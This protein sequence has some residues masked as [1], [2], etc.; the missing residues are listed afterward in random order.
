MA[1]SH[2]SASG[3]RRME[4]SRSIVVL[5]AGAVG[6]YLGGKLADA[7]KHTIT[8][9]GRAGLVDTVSAR[10]LIM[11]E[12]GKKIVTH[13]KATTSAA[14]LPPCDL[15][16]LAVRTYD[17]RDAIKDVRLLDLNRPGVQENGLVL[18]VQNGAGSDDLLP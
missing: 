1:R 4:R 18:G 3:A 2:L 16:I 17:V 13:P 15:V 12:E 10:G 5:G 9:V 8:L 6:G 7:T 11:R 14:Q